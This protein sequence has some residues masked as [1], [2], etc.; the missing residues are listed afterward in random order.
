MPRVG[1][2]AAL[3]VTRQYDRVPR[4]DQPADRQLRIDDHVGDPRLG[5]GLGEVERLAAEQRLQPVA[6]AER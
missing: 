6:D 2:A 5:F 3:I 1:D 4:R